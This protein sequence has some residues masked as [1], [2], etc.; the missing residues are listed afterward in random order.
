MRDVTPARE[1][2]AGRPG[3]GGDLGDG[4]SLDAARPLVR[5]SWLRAKG[6]FPDPA[7]ARIRAVME[8]EQ[9]DAARSRHAVAGLLPLIQSLLAEPARENGLVMAVGDADGHLLWV[10]GSAKARSK[11]EEMGFVAGADWSEASI[12]TS[13]PGLAL[14]TGQAVQVR[15]E[16]HF[17]PLAQGYSC[18]A[19]PLLDPRTGD[20]LGFLDLTGD[21][22]AVDSLIL[23]YLRATAAAVH[24]HLLATPSGREPE[25][26][27]SAIYMVPARGAAG[28][29]RVAADGGADGSGAAALAGASTGSAP[30]NATSRSAVR[31][32]ATGRD[33]ALL[34][35]PSGTT[36]LG[37]RH[38]EILVAL[39]LSP[40]G[41]SAGELIEQVYPSP[42]TAV[43]LRAEL[44]R[45]RKVLEGAGALDADAELGSRPYRLSG[46]ELDGQRAFA[47]LDAGDRLGALREYAG[48]ALPSSEAPRVVRWREELSGTLREA[49]LS[50]GESEEVMAY[51]A[52]P[53]AD[54]DADA[55][56][57]ALRVLPARSPRRAGVLARLEHLERQ[58]A[59]G[60]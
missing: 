60:R 12:G 19:V 54:D 44:A 1:D 58:D 2:A 20:R 56:Q 40:Q 39:A 34:V 49:I 11:A 13:A 46:V 10:D 52:L 37:Q 4:R 36:R 7:D 5:A 9:L 35:T 41:L 38:A 26:A 57:T 24:A 50:D 15:R 8:A 18:S 22:R 43:T 21:D 30:A 17:T 29:A 14:V 32:L 55:W 16:E 53:E 47:L 48:E 27:T 59:A 33:E 23:P 3:T 25:P 45:L 31:V 6:A 51:L 42:V 28:S